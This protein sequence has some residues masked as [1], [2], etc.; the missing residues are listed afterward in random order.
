MEITS[1]LL[2]SSAENFI[3][4]KELNL[5]TNNTNVPKI[6]LKE[7]I[8]DS[9]ILEIYENLKSIQN[10]YTK[11]QV[12]FQYLKDNPEMIHSN[13]KFN[14]EILFP[15]LLDNKDIN[16]E[17]LLNK[18]MKKI[19]ELKLVLKKLEIQQENYFAANFI[20]PK[21]LNIGE[22]SLNLTKLNPDRVSQLT[23]T[24]FTG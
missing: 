24:Q 4:R 10:L 23:R 18:T 12:R 22:L 1:K 17:D 15:E 14:N 8:E 2:L 3:K 5:K 9:K 6:N 19:D 21:D 20:S 11:E 16:K 7:P 13:L